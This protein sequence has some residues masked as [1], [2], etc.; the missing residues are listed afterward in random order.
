MRKFLLVFFVLSAAAVAVWRMPHPKAP[1]PVPTDQGPGESDDFSQRR[2]QWIERMHRHAPGLDWRAQDAATLARLDAQRTVRMTALRMGQ[3]VQALANVPAGTWIERGARN[4]AG[5]VSD[6]D[7][8]TATDRITVFAHGGQLWRSKRATLDWQPLNDTRHFEPYYAMQH[9]ARLS[10]T[11]ERWLVADD[12]RHGFYYSDNQ[13]TTWTQATG[14]VPPYWLQ[15]SYLVARDVTGNQ[16]YALVEDYNFSA[17]AL[18]ARLLVSAD[19][20]ASFVDLGFVGT[21]ENTALFALGQGSNLVYLMVGNVLKRVEVGNTLTTLATIAGTPVQQPND[22]VGLAGG[23]TSGTSPTTFLYAFFEASGQAKVF[24]SLDGG[25]SWSARGTVPAIANVHMAVGTALHDPNFVFFGG[26][27]LYR[28]ADGG[29]TFAYVNDWPAYYGDVVH[30]LHADISFV[31]SFPDTGGNDVFLIGTDGGLYQSTDD[32][33]T[34]TNMNLTGMRQA[35]YYDSYTG[36]APPYVISIGVQDQ[37]YQRNSDPPSGIANFNE[38]IGGDYGDL[39]S[40]N[41]GA[42]LWN[43]YAGFSQIDPAPAAGATTLPRWDFKTDGHL[44]NMLFLPPLLADPTNPYSAWLAGGSATVGLNHVIQLTWNGTVAWTGQITGSEGS[45]DFGGQVTALADSGG[46]FFAM[47]DNASNA[48]SF[49]L[50][51]TPAGAWTKTV[52]TLPQGQFFYGNGIA[53]DSSHGKIYVCGSGYSGPGVYVST[54]NGT[55]F[56]A[57][58]TGLPSTLV[59]NLAISPDGSKLFAATEVGPYFYDQANA[60]WVDIGTGAPDNIYWNVDYV[61]ALNVARFS[62]FGRGLWDYDMG[63]GD[64]IFRNGFE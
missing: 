28:S 58:N 40:S 47:A 3:S 22:K 57:M 20:G 14:F 30:K 5:R 9:F 36:R 12:T 41:G 38:V 52:T 51:T 32:G 19:R 64:L 29:R 50:S 56:A 17:S 60:T 25:A 59:Y 10:G 15:T 2:A 27:D 55:S 39:T 37:G 18:Q 43:N 26:Q 24:Q 45:Y 42:L 61:P 8:D 1:I 34:V 16:V 23:V 46:N 7:Y 21:E 62:T 44:L 13:G 49:F 11:P 33:A 48:A 6:V 31:K 54:N 35:Q 63:G 53:V 4:Q